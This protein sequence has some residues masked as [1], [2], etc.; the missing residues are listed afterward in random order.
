MAIPLFAN[1]P[2]LE[3]LLGEVAERQRAVL[4]SGK[5]I[6]GPEVDA[7]ESEFAA[8]VGAEHG[9]GV[10]KARWLHLARSPQQIAA[11]RAIKAALDPAGIMNPGKLLPE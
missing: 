9:V 10:A 3:P 8:Y 7:F 11:M 4:E 6:L 5:Y 2:S 1:K